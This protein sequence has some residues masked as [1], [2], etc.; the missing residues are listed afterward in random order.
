MVGLGTGANR[1]TFTMATDAAAEYNI[2]A[3]DAYIENI[4]FV[5][6]IAC[7]A[8]I[9][10]TA[11]GVGAHINN[12]E[13]REGSQQHAIMI[14]MTGSANDVIIENS[15][16][17]VPTADTGAIGIDLSALT[18]ARFTF[19][20]N[21]VRGDFNTAAIFGSGALTDANIH[22]NVFE[23]ALA[24]QLAVEFT[25]ASLGVF[26][27][28]FM[29]SS[30]SATVLDP[31]SLNTSGNTWSIGID[32]DAVPFPAYSEFV[33]GYGYLVIKTG[34]DL[35]VDPDNIF[36]VTG[37]VAI[38]LFIGHITTVFS[39]ATTQI[40]LETDG[41]SPMAANTTVDSWVDESLFLLNGDVSIA[42]NGGQGSGV[43]E[44]VSYANSEPNN[45]SIVGKPTD[46]VTIR[47]N[48]T[49]SDTGVYDAY[50]WYIPLTTGATVV[51][52]S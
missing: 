5:D 30:T 51:A 8:C 46:T 6:N 9:E 29:I 52:S 41:G 33:P 42:L 24:G 50:I 16:F 21:V 34:V 27:N 43:I 35:S 7:T 37:M 36:D 17:L 28:N 15:V 49:A 22:D 4:V 45:I 26:Y 14:D 1:P 2:D 25:A 12:I 23:N 11:N 3:A 10:I 48:H 19:R 47:S 44:H 13:I 18:P 20:N 32:Q 31:G 38:T 39:G 40:Q